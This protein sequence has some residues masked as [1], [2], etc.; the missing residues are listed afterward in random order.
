ML[1]V[2]LT[3][4]AEHPDAPGCRPEGHDEILDILDHQGVRATFFL[5]GRW[6]LAYPQA[7]RRMAAAGHL[8]GSHSHYHAPLP[9]LD[10]RALK[11]DIVAAAAAIQATAGLDPRPWFRCPRSAGADDPRVL[12]ALHRHG[13]RN[14]G[15]DV[16][17]KDWEPDRPADQVERVIVESCLTSGDGAIVLLHTWPQ[18]VPGALPGIIAG[19][20]DAGAGFVT[21]A[22]LTWRDTESAGVRRVGT[23]RRIARRL[24][25]TR[26]PTLRR[27]AGAFIRK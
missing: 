25:V 24:G 11:E 12:R 15:A 5:Q 23:S 3:F 20:R 6:A 21:V 1:R 18:S 7:A 14:V 10:R 22:D 4:D 27:V 26:S 8:L 13:F 19:L 17:G 16:D 2:A 9:I